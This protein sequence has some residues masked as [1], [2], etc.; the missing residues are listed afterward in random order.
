MNMSYSDAVRWICAL[1]AFKENSLRNVKDD[2]N[3]IAFT[4]YQ[5]PDYINLTPKEASSEILQRVVSNPDE[6]MSLRMSVELELT[7]RIAELREWREQ[8]LRQYAGNRLL[9]N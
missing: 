5:H 3:A 6:F 1:G 8:L 7:Q 9:N 2:I 4:Y